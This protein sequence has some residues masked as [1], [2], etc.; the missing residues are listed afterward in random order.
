MAGSNPGFMIRTTAFVIV[1]S[2]LPA[3]GPAQATPLV[4]PGERVYRDIDRLAAAGLIETLI[5]GA[6]PFS[7]REV[8]RLLNEALR[9]LDRLPSGNAW[10]RETITADL[11]RYTRVA[12]RAYDSVR[13]EGLALD[14]P[15]RPAPSDPN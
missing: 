3:L 12:N 4:P 10:A 15:Y 7:E 5:I 1:F 2:C 6:R 8:A 11:A 13:L 9:N 14:S